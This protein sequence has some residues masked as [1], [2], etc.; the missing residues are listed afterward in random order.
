MDNTN[1]SDANG[2]A[3]GEENPMV[4]GSPMMKDK[5]IV[6]NASNSKDH[7]TLVSAVKAADL[8]ETLSGEGPFTVFAPTNAAFDKVDKTALE[9]LMKPESKD[10]LAGI[11][12]YHVVAGKMDSKT[13]ADAIKTGN[14]KAVLKTVNGEELT[15]SMDGDKLVLTDAKGG[16][17]TV[18]TADV[19]QSNGVI[20]VVDTVLM[21]K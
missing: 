3:M 19:Y 2:E 20:H 16:K 12:K 6:E 13:I 7:T 9:G 11:L 5:N 8:V 15:A 14:G 4:G 21:P 10:A 1:M 18:T 17:A